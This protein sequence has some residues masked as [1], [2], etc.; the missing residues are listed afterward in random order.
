MKLQHVI[1]QDPDLMRLDT[2]TSSVE[3]HGMP[4]PVFMM[5]NPNEKYATLSE[6]DAAAKDG[7]DGIFYTYGKEG[8]DDFVAGEAWIIVPREYSVLL[9]L[10]YSDRIL[11]TLNLFQMKAVIG[12]CAKTLGNKV[13]LVTLNKYIRFCNSQGILEKVTNHVKT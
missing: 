8:R 7:A 12:S 9:Y 6:I 4:D 10:K 5:M 1:M 3:Y 2:L 11:L 13:D